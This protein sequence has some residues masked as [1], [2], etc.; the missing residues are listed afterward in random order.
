MSHNVSVATVTSQDTISSGRTQEESDNNVPADAALQH[1]QKKL[2][3][4]DEREKLKEELLR[5]FEAGQLKTASHTILSGTYDVRNQPLLQPRA[6]QIPTIEEHRAANAN[7][8]QVLRRTT[9]LPRSAAS[10]TIQP[11]GSLYLPDLSR[12]PPGYTYPQQLPVSAVSSY[13]SPPAQQI[14]TAPNHSYEVRQRITSVKCVF[15]TV[16]EQIFEY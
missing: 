10:L 9:S 12:P 3:T 8:S 6:R 2:K 14:A 15:G 7:P 5:Q 13:I 1:V 16:Y 4:L 11:G